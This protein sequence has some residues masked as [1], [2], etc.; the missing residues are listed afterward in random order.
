MDNKKDIENK[1]KDF[2]YTRPEINFAYI[3]GSFNKSKKY[4]D[5]DVAVYINPKYD[6]NDLNIY[7]FGYEA[8]LLGKLCL[9]L[10]TDKIDLIILNKSNLLLSM[11]VYNSGKLLFERD[12]FLRVRIVNEIRKEYIDTE[13]YRKLKEGYL[14]NYL[15]VR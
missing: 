15:N 11:Q 2:L 4:K 9:I 6:F 13:Q 10:K 5:I 8:E 14:R 1:I 7:P 3:F 12:R